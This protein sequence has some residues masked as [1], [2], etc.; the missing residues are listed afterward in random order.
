[1]CA[2]RGD[3]PDKPFNGNILV[4][5]DPELHR[6]ASIRAAMAG[7]GLSRWI[8]RQIDAAP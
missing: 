6:K 4:R 1:L 7:L 8:S 5:T 3:S 2:E